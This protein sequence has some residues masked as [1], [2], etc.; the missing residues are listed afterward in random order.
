MMQW[1]SWFAHSQL[2]LPTQTVTIGDRYL[3]VVRVSDE[4]H[5]LV[6]N[7]LGRDLAKGF[8]SGPAEA[9]SEAEAAARQAD[10]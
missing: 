5:W 7:R 8:A 2:G 3:M 10:D 6:R 4:W 9:R 1:S